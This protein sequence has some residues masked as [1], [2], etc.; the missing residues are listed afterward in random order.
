LRAA[1]RRGAG[2]SPPG[3]DL[4]RDSEI[5]WGDDGQQGLRIGIEAVMLAAQSIQTGE[6]DIVVAAA[7][8]T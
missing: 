2:S 3:D 8:K 7:S 5:G 4:R 1:G 6:A